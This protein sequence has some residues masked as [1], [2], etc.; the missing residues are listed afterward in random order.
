M[1]QEQTINPSWQIIGTHF[2]P[3]YIEK[4]GYQEEEDRLKIYDS[5]GHYMSYLGTDWDTIENALLSIQE[6]K[7]RMKKAENIFDL[8][9]MFCDSFTASQ[10]WEDL[11]EDLWEEH[12]LC[13]REDGQL[14]WGGDGTP[15]TKENLL[16]NEY[17][18][19]IGDYYILITE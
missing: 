12:V 19:R 10:N 2:G 7:K 4:I 9:G 16:S 11:V 14:L 17:I 5:D 8:V 13:F 1:K 6:D 15:C 18:N 3:I